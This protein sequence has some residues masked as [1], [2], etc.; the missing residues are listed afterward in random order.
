MPEYVRFLEIRSRDQQSIATAQASLGDY[1]VRMRDI[2]ESFSGVRNIDIESIEMPSAAH[3]VYT[4][5]NRLSIQINQNPNN[6]TLNTTLKGL[7]GSPALTT[8]T[9]RSITALYTNANLTGAYRFTLTLP[10]G[11]YS[12]QDIAS[13]LQHQMDALV[14]RQNGT[15]KSSLLTFTVDP[16]TNKLQIMASVQT[17]TL[18]TNWQI[19]DMPGAFEIINIP[20]FPTDRVFG[21][22]QR[23]TTVV[24]TAVRMTPYDDFGGTGYG[25]IAGYTT[26]T[27]GQPGYVTQRE[28]VVM[29]YILDVNNPPAMYLI[30]MFG[31]EKFVGTDSR[32]Y[33]TAPVQH[34]T[35]RIQQRAPGF[36]TTY[37][38]KPGINTRPIQTADLS[39]TSIQVKICDADGNPIDFNG[40]HHSFIMRIEGNDDKR[41]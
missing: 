11:T 6:T 24:S 31:S 3:N 38:M 37:F 21:Y 17:N 41:R 34:V 33:T 19:L 18:E 27:T 16:T 36:G 22:D 2:G 40:M 10:S 8:S 25:V 30:L 32:F 39:F 9:G 15:N 28:T 14:Y 12:P 13:A 23:N 29:P 1:N 5:N 4:G 20:S 26:D 35:A 7:T